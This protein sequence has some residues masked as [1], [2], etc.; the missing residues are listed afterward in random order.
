MVFKVFLLSRFHLVF[1][2]STHAS[3]PPEVTL[4]NC[5]T[6]PRDSATDIEK[7]PEKVRQRESNL[8]EA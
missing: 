2:P 4:L 8:I 1:L 3:L 6:T 5:S 7:N